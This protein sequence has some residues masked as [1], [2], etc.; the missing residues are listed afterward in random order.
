MSKKSLLITNDFPPIVSG[1]STAFSHLWQN[2][3]IDRIV[4]LAPWIKGCAEFDKA[5][6]FKILRK[7]IPIGE[8][9]F[10]KLFKSVLIAFYPVFLISRYK[11]RKLHC[12]QILSTGLAGMLC[13]RLFGIPYA[14]YVYGS[15]TFRFKDSRLLLSFINKIID[16][17]D[18]LI[19]NSEFTLN[20]FLS[21]GVK[22]E[23]MVKIVPGV[24]TTNFCPANISLSLVKK[25]NLEG[26]RVL[27]T[28][29]RLDERK[30]HDMVIRAL[31][32]VLEK[33]PNTKYLI[34]GRGREKSRL[35]NLAMELGLLDAGSQTENVIF[36]G[37][38]EDNDLPHYYN[39]CDAFIMPNRETSEHKQ[40]RGDLEG[41][42]IVFME[43][44]ACEKPVI[45]G[46]SG[47]AI[48]AVEDGITG[49]FVDPHSI[50]DI[51]NTIIR[52]FDDEL[53]SKRLAQEGRKRAKLQY[54][55]KL[56]SKTLMEIL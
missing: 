5:Q 52:L 45:A 3:P 21:L 37:Y 17:A 35:Q 46:R 14:V 23:K 10:S 50:E 28:V 55:W 39:L 49:L 40:L 36:A 32:K 44:S 12:G 13:K 26:N 51:S 19:P 27:L 16:E 54:D 43:A 42:G 30:G 25:Y 4:I 31:P 29:G 2:L 47:G 11:I 1:I 22:K 33:Y 34:V 56:L 48:E 18:E 6:S 8:S 41:F 15:E 24:D 20:E 9:S 38:V 53:L 7:W